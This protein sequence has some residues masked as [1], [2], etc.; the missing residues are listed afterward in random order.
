MQCFNEEEDD[1][2]SE[3]DDHVYSDSCKKLV[4]SECN[5][6]ENSIDSILLRFP[7]TSDVVAFGNDLTRFSVSE[8]VSSRLTSLDLEDNPFKTLD[9]IHG[10]FPNL[11]QLSVANCGITSLNGF[12]GSIKFPKLE[13]LNIKRNSIVEWKSVNSIRSLKSLK[14]LLFDCKKLSTEK[15][16]HA[17]EIVIAKL[18]TLIDLNRFDVSEVERR[19]AEIRFLNKYAGLNDNED[20]QDDIKRLIE[21]HGEPTLDTAKKGL[22]VVKIRIE[23][24]NRVETRRLPL[25]MSIQKIRDMLAR[26]FKVPNTSKIRLYL[27]MSEKAKQHRIELENPLREFGHYSPSEDRDILVV[28]HD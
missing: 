12:D 24:G 25:G 21:I 16:V 1:D 7:S 9:S 3:G 20:H 18:S 6:S 27:V 10:T 14:R 8:A 11:T 28:E 2:E 15:G 23:C 22:A 26:L 4:I 13:Y 17:Y 19:S 5:L